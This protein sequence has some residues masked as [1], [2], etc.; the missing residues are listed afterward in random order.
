MKRILDIISRILFYKIVY[1]NDKKYYYVVGRGI[2]PN[3]WVSVDIN[4]QGAYEY[5]PFL[6][7][8]HS[9]NKEYN[10]TFSSNHQLVKR[11][12]KMKLIGSHYK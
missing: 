3:A 2:Q 4:D 7:S 11:Y 8:A 5:H 10:I 1:S 12:K 6:F 9:P